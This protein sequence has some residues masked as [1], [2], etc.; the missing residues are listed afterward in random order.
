MPTPIPNVVS[1]NMDSNELYAK[2]V[3]IEINESSDSCINWTGLICTLG[4]IVFGTIIL[5]IMIKY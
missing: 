4:L 2:L 1:S 3:Q 5:M